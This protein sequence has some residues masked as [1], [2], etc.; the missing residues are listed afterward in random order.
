M[1]YS[2][3]EAQKGLTNKFRSLLLEN[4]AFLSLIGMRRVE[5]AA[6]RVRHIQK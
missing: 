4:V 2:G 3:K 1:V 6:C 5:D